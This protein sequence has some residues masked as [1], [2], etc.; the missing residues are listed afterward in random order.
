[1]CCTCACNRGIYI[2]G[3]GGTA[4]Q[5][6]LGRRRRWRGHRWLVGGTLATASRAERRGMR[7]RNGAGMCVKACRLW[8][9][10]GSGPVC[11]CPRCNGHHMIVQESRPWR[12]R[13]GFVCT[14]CAQRGVRWWGVACVHWRRCSRLAVEA[15]REVSEAMAAMLPWWGYYF[16]PFLHKT[17][18]LVRRKHIACKLII[19]KQDD[20]KSWAP[21]MSSTGQVIKSSIQVI[22]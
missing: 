5:C 10:Q 12:M 1:M 20:N 9:E 8:Q 2:G 18:S 3:S 15:S 4:A 17:Q 6:F 21:V 11:A 19:S 7:A 13:C 14:A 22:R 16:S